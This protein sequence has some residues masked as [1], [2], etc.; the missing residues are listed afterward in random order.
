MEME[1][2]RQEKE[3]LEGK[4]GYAVRKSMEILLALGEIFGAK[5]LT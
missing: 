2:T 4:E 1:L 3:M 5:N